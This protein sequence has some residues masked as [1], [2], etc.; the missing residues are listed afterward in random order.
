MA[1]SFIVTQGDVSQ[2]GHVPVNTLLISQSFLIAVQRPSSV[3]I[4]PVHERCLVSSRYTR[5]YETTH[6]NMSTEDTHRSI[7]SGG[8]R[9]APLLRSAQAP[10]GLCL[11]MQGQFELGVHS[12]TNNR[13]RAIEI[14]TGQLVE[15]QANLPQG[16]AAAQFGGNLA[17]RKRQLSEHM[18]LGVLTKTKP[19]DGALVL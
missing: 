17:C 14:H 16:T 6:G 7:G 2:R 18:L 11:C 12:F 1:D 4:V 3:G 10:S 13:I 19:I 15:S 5:L 9:C 8:A